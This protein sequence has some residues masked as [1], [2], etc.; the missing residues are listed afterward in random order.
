VL[1]QSIHYIIGNPVAFVFGQALAKSPNQFRSTSQGKGNRETKEVATGSHCE[2][3]RNF[4]NKIHRLG[5]GV[6]RVKLDCKIF[7]SLH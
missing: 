3:F 5:N 2:S 7:C 4:N 6:S 1:F